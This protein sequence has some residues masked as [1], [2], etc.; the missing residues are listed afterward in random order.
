MDPHGLGS[1]G[2]WAPSLSLSE[3]GGGRYKAFS[4]TGETSPLH[5]RVKASRQI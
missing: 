3:L 1:E 5:P 2:S 4:D